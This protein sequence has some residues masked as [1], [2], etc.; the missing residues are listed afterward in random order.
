VL[1]IAN[2]A[3]AIASA[4]GGVALGTVQAEMFPT[5]VRGTSNALLLVA[6]V[7]GSAIGLI[8]A[9]VLS[10]P[11]GL[12]HALALCGIG[13]LL[14]AAFLLP[15]LPESARRSLDDV[16]PTGS[17]PA[18]PNATDSKPTDE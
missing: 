15:R 9:G 14:A 11:I 4:A 3:S 10:D 2:T 1:W 5:E 8:G 16:S 17:N 12:G 13:A 7:V 6:G 18:E